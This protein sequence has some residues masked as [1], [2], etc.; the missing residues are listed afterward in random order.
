MREETCLAG[1]SWNPTK[2]YICE[3]RMIEKGEEDKLVL[4]QRGLVSMRLH[5]AV[6]MR[7]SKRGIRDESMY[8]LGNCEIMA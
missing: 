3:G 4:W 6:V 8:I 2:L 7:K 1:F 5:Q